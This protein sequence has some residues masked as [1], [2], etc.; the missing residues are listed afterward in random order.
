MVFFLVSFLFKYF[1]STNHI[2]EIP[3]EKQ[4]CK[5]LNIDRTSLGIVISWRIL[6]HST[7]NIILQISDVS[8]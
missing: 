5:N 2:N 7:K 8:G 6:I 3:R 4:S 1:S